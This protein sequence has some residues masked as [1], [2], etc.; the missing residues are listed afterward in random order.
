LNE[1]VDRITQDVER[2]TIALLQ[3]GEA[4]ESNTPPTLESLAKRFPDV[5]SRLEAAAG[6]K[7][8]AEVQSDAFKS[9]C[10]VL[11]QVVGRLEMADSDLASLETAL[12]G[13]LISIPPS[14]IEAFLS[15]EASILRRLGLTDRHI[16]IATTALRDVAA[17]GGL[18]DLRVDA[19]QVLLVLRTLRDSLC[20]AQTIAGRGW[21]L[22]SKT[23][24][25]GVLVACDACIVAGDL[26][27]IPVGATA[28]PL[29][30]AAATLAAVGSVGGGLSSLMTRLDGL[31]GSLRRDEE[32]E[33][34]HRDHEAAMETI[35]KAGPPGRLKLKGEKDGG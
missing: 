28:G 9:A 29:G 21:K 14:G 33:K 26:L 12:S 2:A 27:A 34:A 24:E 19:K 17:G 7:A 18:R 5:L 11:T 6:A 8:S 3:L 31:L 13:F 32:A 25:Q 10:D 4:M 1:R 23:V 16:E 15:N 22:S 30:L 20:R 35:R